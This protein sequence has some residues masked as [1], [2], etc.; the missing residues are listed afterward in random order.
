MCVCVVCVRA[1]ACV[2]V[3]VCACACVCV[4]VC[5]CVCAFTRG[6]ADARMKLTD[7]YKIYNDTLARS[8]VIILSHFIQTHEIRQAIV[9]ERK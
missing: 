1:C 6:S 5:V 3:C 9:R 8:G 4:C 2:C 7:L